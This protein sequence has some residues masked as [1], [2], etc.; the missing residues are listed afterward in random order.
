[1]RESRSRNDKRSNWRYYVDWTLWI[2]MFG[3]VFYGVSKGVYNKTEITVDCYGYVKSIDGQYYTGNDTITELIEDGFFK[4]LELEEKKE[5]EWGLGVVKQLRVL[6][7]QAKEDK[8]NKIK[9]RLI[10]SIKELSECFIISDGDNEL[11]LDNLEK[12]SV[13]ELCELMDE[14]LNIVEKEI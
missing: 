14:I 5:R 8:N 1:M 4:G 9:V 6:I 11:D 13:D 10:K 2:I 12:L 3:L 7:E